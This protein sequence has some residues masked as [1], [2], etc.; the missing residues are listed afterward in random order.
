MVG[1][2]GDAA[3]I[4]AKKAQPASPIIDEVAV[5]RVHEAVR[6]SGHG[7]QRR[8]ISQRGFVIEQSACGLEHSLF[9]AGSAGAMRSAWKVLLRVASEQH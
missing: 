4:D 9:S 5:G 1:Q 2:A 7:V 3:Q 8:E 6:P